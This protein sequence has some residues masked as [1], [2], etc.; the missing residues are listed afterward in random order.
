[1][2]IFLRTSI[3]TPVMKYKI[4]RILLPTITITITRAD[5]PDGEIIRNLP[6][7][8]FTTT[9]WDGVAAGMVPDGAVGTA[10]DG[11]WDGMTPSGIWDGAV[12]GTVPDGVVAGM[13]PD[14]DWAGVTG[15]D[16]PDGDGVTIART[17]ILPEGPMPIQIPGG[18]TTA[19]I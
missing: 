11:E 2:I 13:V 8:I 16:I 1:M 18:I 14:G 5:I 15:A 10:P 4:P 7:L 19:T 3:R 12:V 9:P 6:P 17:T